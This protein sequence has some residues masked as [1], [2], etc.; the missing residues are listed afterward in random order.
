MPEAGGKRETMHKIKR[1]RKTGV[2]EHKK[3]VQNKTLEDRGGTKK[4]TNIFGK[5]PKMVGGGGAQRQ[6]WKKKKKA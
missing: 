2:W 3:I 4:K 1:V 6:V 5:R